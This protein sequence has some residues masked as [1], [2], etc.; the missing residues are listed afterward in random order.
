MY[1]ATEMSVA[2]I[3]LLLASPLC[4]SNDATSIKIRK[5]RGDLGE[6]GRG[7]GGAEER[8]F[9]QREAVWPVLYLES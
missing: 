7:T 6:G 8:R 5:G 9:D 4:G 1:E 3:W 2:N